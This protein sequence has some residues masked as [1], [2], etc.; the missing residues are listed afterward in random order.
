VHRAASGPRPSLPESAASP[1]AH[2]EGH[3]R[4]E[5]QSSSLPFET[6]SRSSSE[7]RT[8]MPWS[9]LVCVSLQKNFRVS[10]TST[11]PTLP[12]PPAAKRVQRPLKKERGSLE[13]SHPGSPKDTNRQT[14][15]KTDIRVDCNLTDTQSLLL[16]LIHLYY[17]YRLPELIVVVVNFSELICYF[18]RGMLIEG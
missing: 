5:G 9:I 15:L 6:Y 11:N 7:K 17:R 13:S 3:S 14:S 10:P 16:C 12:S 8:P 2:D 18:P 4:E 1:Q